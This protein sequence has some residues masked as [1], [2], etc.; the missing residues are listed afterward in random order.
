MERKEKKE[1]EERKKVRKKVQ[2]QKEREK[3][4]GYCCPLAILTLLLLLFVVV[5]V[6]LSV[7]VSL[8]AGCLMSQKHAGVSQGRICEDNCTCCHTEIKLQIKLSV[9]PNHSILTPGRP[10]PALTLKRQAPGRVATGVPIF[11]SLV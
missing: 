7:L 6:V 1:R 2:R 5:I 3:S 11:K 9:S 8:L 4:K 10:V